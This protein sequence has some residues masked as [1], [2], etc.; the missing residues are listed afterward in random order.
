MTVTELKHS[1]EFNSSDY[2]AIVVGKLFFKGK[3]SFKLSYK[4]WYFYKILLGF[5]KYNTFLGGQ[6]KNLNT[7]YLK[8]NHL[9]CKEGI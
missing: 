5:Y 2:D 1:K 8:K 9:F 3:V 7:K 6:S 4:S